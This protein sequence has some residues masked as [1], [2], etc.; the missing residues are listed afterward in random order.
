MRGGSIVLTDTSRNGIYI[1]F[2][3]DKFYVVQNTVVLHRSGRMALG[4]LPNEPDA[5]FAEFQIE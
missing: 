4:Q 5:I 2:G 1:A 3:T